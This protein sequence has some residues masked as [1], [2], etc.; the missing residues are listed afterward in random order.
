MPVC[1]T[2]PP[3]PPPKCPEYEEPPKSYSNVMYEPNFGNIGMK[4]KCPTNKNI[5]TWVSSPR[6]MYNRRKIVKPQK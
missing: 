3:Q 6:A 1:R 4:S 5:Y 2:F